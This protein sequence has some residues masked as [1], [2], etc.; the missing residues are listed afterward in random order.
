[1]MK[2]EQPFVSKEKVNPHS[3]FFGGKA[4]KGGCPWALGNVKIQRP[5]HC[6]F[7]NLY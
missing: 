6:I 7:Y 3:W 5:G 1:M 4:E 2:V